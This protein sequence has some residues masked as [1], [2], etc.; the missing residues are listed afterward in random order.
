MWAN[1]VRRRQPI[2]KAYQQPGGFDHS[3]PYYPDHEN[4]SNPVNQLFHCNR[5][6]HDR[7][8]SIVGQRIAPSAFLASTVRRYR[9]LTHLVFWFS[10]WLRDARHPKRG[11]RLWIRQPGRSVTI[12]R[13]GGQ[14]LKNMLPHSI[15]DHW[16]RV[17][18][19]SVNF[20]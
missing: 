5:N 10:S 3:Q 19:F 11:H 7:P 9:R 12:R 16:P 20:V 15:R 6:F 1:L 4:Y 14:G 18:K 8:F 13:S 2:H 17:L